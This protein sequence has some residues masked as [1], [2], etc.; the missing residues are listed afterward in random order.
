[1]TDEFQEVYK[2]FFDLISKL[3]E[4]DKKNIS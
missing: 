1:M 2:S 4:E 3:D